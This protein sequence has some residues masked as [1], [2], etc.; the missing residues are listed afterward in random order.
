MSFVEVRAE[1]WLWMTASEKR[2]KADKETNLE[3]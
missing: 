3:W 1:D 2:E